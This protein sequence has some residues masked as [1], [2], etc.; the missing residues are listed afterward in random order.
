[1]LSKDVLKLFHK[2]GPKRIE[3]ISGIR[4]NIVFHDQFSCQRALLSLSKPLKSSLAYLNSIKT[5][6]NDPGKLI[7]LIAWRSANLNS[8][9]ATLFMR[10]ANINDVKKKKQRTKA[11]KRRLQIY[12]TRMTNKSKIVNKK[13]RL[14][15]RPKFSLKELRKQQAQESNK[16]SDEKNTNHQQQQEEVEKEEQQQEVE[17]EEQ[18]QEEVEKEE[19]QQTDQEVEQQQQVENAI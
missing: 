9:Y 2:F 12:M 7:S 3:W 15:S 1:M 18:Q 6:T 19:Q 5:S 4:C 11:E 14:E 8:K 13:R 17:K 10:M 16:P